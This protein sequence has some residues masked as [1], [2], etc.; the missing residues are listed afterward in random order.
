MVC[1]MFV[2]QNWTL[3]HYQDYTLLARNT[4]EHLHMVRGWVNPSILWVKRIGGGG[5]VQGTV[6]LDLYVG[7]RSGRVV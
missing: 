1:S 6:F 5:G 3:H 4:L 2:P 7:W